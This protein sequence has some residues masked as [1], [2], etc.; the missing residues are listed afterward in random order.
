MGPLLQHPAFGQH[1]D[2][3]G[4]AHGGEAV[5]DEERGAPRR[6]VGE[7]AEHLG[8]GK[9]VAINNL[10]DGPTTMRGLRP[11]MTVSSR[12]VLAG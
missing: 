12:T 10:R 3:V 6:E 1:H 5:R 2:P 11:D 7:A 9:R 8:L 4:P